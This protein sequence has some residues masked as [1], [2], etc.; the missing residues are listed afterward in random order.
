MDLD[1]YEVSPKTFQKFID[2][3][4][5]LG[6]EEFYGVCI[7]LGIKIEDDESDPENGVLKY[8]EPDL[9]LEEVLDTFCTLDRK[10]RKNLMR[11]L[12][13]TTKGR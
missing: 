5:K 10:K 1:K 4:L 8:K 2:Q 7:I 13:K 6:P 9:L 3:I 12:N 11:I